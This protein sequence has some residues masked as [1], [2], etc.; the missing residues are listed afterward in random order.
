MKTIKKYLLSLGYI[1][2][3]GIDD[4]NHYFS[5][6]GWCYELVSPHSGNGYFYLWRS[7]PIETFDKWSYCELEERFKTVKEFKNNIQ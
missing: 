7:N 3:Y 2:D 6:D 5:K 4:D 1:F